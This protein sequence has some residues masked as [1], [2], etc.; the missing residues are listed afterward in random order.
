MIVLTRNICFSDKYRVVLSG[1]VISTTFRV[2]QIN[3]YALMRL[4]CMS[5]IGR[6]RDFIIV[7]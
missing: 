4:C 7:K 1:L 3:C 5:G 2:M 6:D